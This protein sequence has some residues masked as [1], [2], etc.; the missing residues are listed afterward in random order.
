MHLAASIDGH[1]PPLAQL[2]MMLDLLN[3]FNQAKNG[4]GFT[5]N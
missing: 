3:N 2:A 4:R 1:S 5:L